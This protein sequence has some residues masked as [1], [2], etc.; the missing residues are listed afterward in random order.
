MA[1]AKKPSNIGI[2]DS[3]FSRAVVVVVVFSIIVAFIIIFQIRLRS[4]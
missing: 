3:S 4:M 2:L 1:S